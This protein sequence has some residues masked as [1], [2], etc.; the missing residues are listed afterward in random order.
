MLVA[1]WNFSRLVAAHA[2]LG[3]WYSPCTL[4][5]ARSTTASWRI[6]HVSGT[7]LWI[8]GASVGLIVGSGFGSS[9]MTA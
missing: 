7:V 2:P 1:L 6:A 4:R 5:A 3:C 8:C 9:G